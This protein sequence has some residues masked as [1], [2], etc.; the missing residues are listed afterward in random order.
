MSVAAGEKV[1]I[2]GARYGKELYKKI[3]TEKTVVCFTDNDKSLWGTS[4]YGIPVF[5][6]EEAIEMFYDRIYIGTFT[7]MH[8]VSLQLLH[9]GVNTLSIDVS[10]VSMPVLARESFIQNL[11]EEIYKQNVA[12]SV[13]EAGVYRG[14]FAK[15][16]NHYFFD[17]KLYLFDTFSGFTSEDID[18]DV[19]LEKT[20]AMFIGKFNNTSE[21]LV[22]SKMPYPE[23]CII[24]KGHFPETTQGIEE[25]FCFVNLDMDL[26][27]PTLE[28]L[29]FFVPKMNEGGVILIHDYFNESFPNIKKAVDLFQSESNIKLIK[30]PIGD[31]WSLAII[32]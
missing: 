31:A 15:M 3:E 30:I 28:G 4:I 32:F 8:E 23:N 20:D 14:E 6:P 18:T 10:Y 27:M 5:P 22:M 9:M 2:F 26:F 7:G 24:R 19:S 1:I 13:A 16:I 21:E 29:R 17:R 12:G 25:K 11:S